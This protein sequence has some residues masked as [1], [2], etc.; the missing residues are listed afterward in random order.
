MNLEFTLRLYVLLF[1]VQFFPIKPILPTDLEDQL[2][3]AT[4]SFL[5][6][7]NRN[8][9]TT[10]QIK[11][12]KIFKWFAKDFKQNGTLIDFLN[13]Y[14]EVTISEKAKKSFKDYNWSLNE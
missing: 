5:A 12:S 9:I 6:D 2:T 8:E 10:D 4:K 11:L 3:T 14:A 1:P 13:Q 7:S